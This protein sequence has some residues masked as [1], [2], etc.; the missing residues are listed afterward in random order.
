MVKNIKKQIL[1]NIYTAFQHKKSKIRKPV[2]NS[3][4]MKELLI[5]NLITNI[6]GT[7]AKLNYIKGTPCLPNIIK[8]LKNR[9]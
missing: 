7:K 4:T 6:E 8:N 5:I 2:G 1:N 3:K 9:N